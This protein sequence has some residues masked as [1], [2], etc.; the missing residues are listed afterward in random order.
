MCS[1]RQGGRRCEE[2]PPLYFFCWQNRISA[3]VAWKAFL[4]ITASRFPRAKTFLKHPRNTRADPT[5]TPLTA[6]RILGAARTV[7]IDMISERA[8][9]VSCMPRET[10]YLSDVMTLRLV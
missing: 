5:V 10:L 7:V 8:L 4:R 6:P 9:S 3:P 1:G 2:E